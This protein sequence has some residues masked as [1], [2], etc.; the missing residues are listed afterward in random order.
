MPI[1]RSKKLT[2]KWR[3]SHFRPVSVPTLVLEAPSEK[4]TFQF[5]V[6]NAK[7]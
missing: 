5:P 1:H 4:M 3:R 7:C 2:G 6:Q